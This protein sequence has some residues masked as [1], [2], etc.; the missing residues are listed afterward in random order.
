GISANQKYG[1]PPW[2]PRDLAATR[3]SGVISDSSPSSGFSA[4]TMTRNGPPVHGAAGA[5]RTAI[6]AASSQ[7]PNKPA[8]RASAAGKR[9]PKRKTKQAPAIG[10]NAA[11]AGT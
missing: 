7:E 1:G 6:S 3:P 10:N 5:E 11:P 2:R 9:A 4:A 8:A